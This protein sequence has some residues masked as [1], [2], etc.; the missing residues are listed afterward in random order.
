LVKTAKILFG[1]DFCPAGEIESYYRT[2]KNR[3]LLNGF[4]DL[5]NSVDYRIVNLECP[6]T[7]ANTPIQKTGPHLKASPDMVGLLK[8]IKIDMVTLANNHILDYGEKGLNDTIET[9]QKAEIRTI[10][11]GKN[12]HEAGENCLIQFD[13]FSISIINVCEREFS[14]AG[15]ESAGANPFDFYST[16]KQIKKSKET[17]SFVFVVYHGGNEHYNLP[18]PRLRKT[19]RFLADMGADAVISHHTHCYSGIENYLGKPLV[20]SLGNFLFYEETDFK[21]WYAGY[22]I[23]FE[24][25]PDG[26]QNYSV[27]PYEQ[28]KDNLGL[29][30]LNPE[31]KE[32]FHSTFDK[33]S[34]IIQNDELLE[35]EWNTF[36][37]KMAYPYLNMLNP[38][39]KFEKPILQILKKVFKKRYFRKSTLR[40][41]NIIRNEAHLDVLKAVLFN[42]QMKKKC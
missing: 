3:S 8:D 6:L 23:T 26:I 39:R 12:L 40:Q 24:I 7:D 9:C 18:S 35:N 13:G 5:F 19:F 20:Y 16:A 36:T 30:L 10:G 37:E 25:N 2:D 42:S 22:T 4:I 34:R 11:A 41:L 38:P 1:G 21:P 28:C 32:D 33:L 27:T 31:Q 29:K 17:A 14:I 15:K